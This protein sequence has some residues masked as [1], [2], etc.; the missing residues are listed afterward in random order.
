MNKLLLS[1]TALLLLAASAKKRTMC[2]GISTIRQNTKRRWSNVKTT[3]P[4]SKTR[5]PASMQTKRHGKKYAAAIFFS[6]P[7]NARINPQSKAA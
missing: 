5:P 3:P 6:S 1:A 7:I 2:S 4:N